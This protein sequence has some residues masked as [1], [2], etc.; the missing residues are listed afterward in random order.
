MADEIPPRSL[1]T[2][3]AYDVVALTASA[4]GFG[5]LSAVLGSL[6][7]ISRRRSWSSSTSTLGIEA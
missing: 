1:V 7:A 3:A 6:E 5:A 4:G 2:G